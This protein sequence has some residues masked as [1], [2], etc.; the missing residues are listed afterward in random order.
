M[1]VA[2]TGHLELGVSLA[3]TWEGLSPHFAPEEAEQCSDLLTAVQLVR[4]GLP[5]TRPAAG[6][7]RR[8]ICRHHR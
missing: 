8:H 6:P 5:Q 7:V 1:V 2:S 4:L 3:A